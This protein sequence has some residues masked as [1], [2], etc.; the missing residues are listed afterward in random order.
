MKRKKLIARELLLGMFFGLLILG[1]INYVHSQSTDYA[2]VGY[3]H[4]GVAVV[5]REHNW[6]AINNDYGYI[7]EDGNQVI[8]FRYMFAEDFNEGLAAVSEDGKKYG[9]IDH[10]GNW[11]IEPQFDYAEDF[12]NGEATVR[13]GIHRYVISTDGT[14]IREAKGN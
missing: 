2:Y 14:C 6:W 1:G 11:A 9:Y 13:I 10:D 8:E 5:R 3:F 12:Y 7:D 4:E